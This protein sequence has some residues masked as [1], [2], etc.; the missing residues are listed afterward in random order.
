MDD[1]IKKQVRARVKETEKANPKNDDGGE[2]S[3]EIDSNF[4]LKCLKLEELGDAEIFKFLNKDMFVFVKSMDVWMFWA[5]HHWEIDKMDFARTAVDG[6]AKAYQNVAKSIN[7]EINKLLAEDKPVKEFQNLRKALNRRA[8]ALRTRRRRENCLYFA[9]TS[10]NPMAIIGTE[11]DQK[12][13]L[14]PC[15]NGVVNLQTGELEQGRQKDYLLRA[16]P[17]EYP[18]NTKDA[19]C[20]YLEKAL[21]EIFSGS[22][23]LVVFFQI[24]LGSVLVGEVVQNIFVVLTGRGRNGKSLIMKIVEIILG[25]LAITIKPEM[26]LKQYRAGGSAGPS[27]DKMAFRAARLAVGHEP[28]DNSHWAPGTIKW[29]SG[30]DTMV[31][32][33]PFEKYEVY[34]E[35]SHTL[36]LLTNFK[37]HAPADDFAFW[38]RMILIPFEVSFVDREPTVSFERRSDPELKAKLELELPG[39]LAWMVRG[40]LEWQKQGCRLKQPQVVKEAVQEYRRDEDIIADFVEQCCIVGPEYHVNAT[41]AYESF[42]EWWKLNV[43]TKV[44][45]QKKFGTLFK[46]RFKREKGQTVEYFGVGLLP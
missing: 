32:R 15:P 3:N 2:S 23:S 41:K 17:I 27:P 18:E 39:V 10:N 1:D 37:P 14:L 20:P 38:E 26:L 28:E 46:K 29:M 31:A 8:S 35:P 16:C 19:S 36:F 33:A 7:K 43:S 30:G 21:F 42:K 40:C 9:H 45:S 22:T 34:F 25:P 11:I 24:L 12:P 5:G 6:V 44:Q 13:W 4:V